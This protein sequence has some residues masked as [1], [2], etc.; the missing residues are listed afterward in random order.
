MARFIVVGEEEARKAPN[1]EDYD[2]GWDD[3]LSYLIDTESGEI[4]YREGGEPED[5]TL[6]RDLRFFVDK[7]NEL[8]DE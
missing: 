5:Q 6:G 4:I 2:Y 7:M 8:A 1:W 3:W